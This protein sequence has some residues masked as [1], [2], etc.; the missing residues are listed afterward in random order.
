[1]NIFVQGLRRSGT[2]IVFDIFWQDKGL[3]CYYEPLGLIDMPK[4]EEAGLRV[5]ITLKR[6]GIFANYSGSRTRDSKVR[7]C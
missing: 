2:T 6:S 5:L 1:M 4:E 3:D 7:I